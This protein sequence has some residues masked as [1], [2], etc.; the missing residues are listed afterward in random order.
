[1]NASLAQK[2]AR[3]WRA[4]FFSPKD[5]VRR[6]LVIVLAF[7]A[8]HLAGL[9]EFTTILNGTI[10]SVEM[11]WGMSA[12]LGLTYIF[13]YLAFVLLVPTLLLAAAFVLLFRKIFPTAR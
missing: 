12:V 11:G 9:R 2:L 7:A 4:E 1:M 10:G 8:V 3:L 6:A 13:V 5:F